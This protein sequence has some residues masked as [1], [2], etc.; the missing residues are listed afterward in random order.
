MADRPP[1][2]VGV[3]VYEGLK[4]T[5]VKPGKW[6]VISGIGGLGHMD[7]QYAGRQHACCGDRRASRKV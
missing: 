1:G 5:E 2:C 3:T 4:E 7:V 6:V